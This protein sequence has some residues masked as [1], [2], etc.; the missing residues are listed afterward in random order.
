MIMGHIHNGLQPGNFHFALGCIGKTLE[1]VQPLPMHKI[2][3]WFLRPGLNRPDFCTF[4]L[5]IL[6]WARTQQHPFTELKSQSKIEASPLLIEHMFFLPS[7][8]AVN[9]KTLTAEISFL[10]LILFVQ[11]KL[12]KYYS[13]RWR[14]LFNVKVTIVVKR[15]MDHCLKCA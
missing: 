9:P 3:H 6:G 13:S 2:M 4:F 11:W 7:E 10:F 14:L 1:V 15:V 8:F 12:F 5:Q